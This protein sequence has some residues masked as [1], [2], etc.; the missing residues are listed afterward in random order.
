MI[1]PRQPG[2]H[3]NPREGE[4]VVEDDTNDVQAHQQPPEPS[5]D[6]KTPDR[7]VGRWEM[8]GGDD[9]WSE[10]ERDP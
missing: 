10:S 4:A 1:R 9:C 6:L 7:L 8:S 2:V 3:R 5:P